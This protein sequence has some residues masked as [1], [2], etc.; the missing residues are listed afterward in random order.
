MSQGTLVLRG[1]FLGCCFVTS[2]IIELCSDMAV[3][4]NLFGTFFGVITTP[5]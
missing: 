2:S 3:G 4:Q 5:S 1:L